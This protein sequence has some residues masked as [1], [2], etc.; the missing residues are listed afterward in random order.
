VSGESDRDL[1]IGPD[2]EPP[3]RP[4]QKG[5]RKRIERLQPLPG[6]FVRVPLSWICAPRKGEYPFPPEWRLYLLVLYRSHWG[7]RGVPITTAFR[8]D[9]A[10]SRDTTYGCLKRLAA[11][12]LLRIERRPGHA[13]VAWPIVLNE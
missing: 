2:D 9:I 11:K 13:L 5:R 6:A 12:G 3:N 1:F 8:A 10:V 7:Q 4:Q